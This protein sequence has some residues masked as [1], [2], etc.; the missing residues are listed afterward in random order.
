MW[1][2]KLPG[3]ERRERKGEWRHKGF[4]ARLQ[5]G[6]KTAEHAEKAGASRYRDQCAGLEKQVMEV[7]GVAGVEPQS[8]CQNDQAEHQSTQ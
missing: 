3:E 5:A 4:Y 2:E 1:L 8:C 6:T 7:Q